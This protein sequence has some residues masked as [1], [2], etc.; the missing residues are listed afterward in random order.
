LLKHLL[1]ATAAASILAMV[2]CSGGGAPNVPGSHATLKTPT[3]VS[4][5]TFKVAPMV[6]TAIQPASAMTSRRPATTIVPQ[7]WSSIP[8]TATAVT[9]AADGSIWVLSDQPA[10]AN[11]FI[12]H[13]SAGTWT[14]V[15]G[16]ASQIA[17]A[18]NG[19]LYAVNATGGVY[20]YSSGSWTG[21]GGGASAVTA[22]SDNTVYVISNAGSGDQAIYHYASN[23]WTQVN[24]EGVSIVGS[25]DTTSH[26]IPNGT[27]VPGGLYIVNSIGSIYYENPDNTFVQ[28]PAN[29]AEVASSP[30][31]LFAL[32]YPATGSGTAIYYYDLDTPGWGA[33]SGSG[34]SIASNDGSLFVIS[35]SG[36]IYST[37]IAAVPTPAGGATPFPTPAATPNLTL[38]CDTSAQRCG[39][40]RWRSKTLDDVNENQINWTPNTDTVAQLNALPVPTGYNEYGPGGNDVGRFPPYEM[41]LFT[42]RA[43][44]ITR[45][46]ETG[47]SGDDDYH[48]EISDPNNPAAT[49]VTEAPH[50]ECTYAC[51]S[52]FGGFFDNI[53]NELDT[54]FGAATSSFQAFPAGVV[55]NFTGVGFF[56]GLHG[57]TG[58]LANPGSPASNFELHPLLYMEFVSGKPNVAGC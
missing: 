32:G 41:E 55:V 37:P 39:V 29:A 3:G 44:L 1:T 21:L 6:T 8:G 45:K 10:G 36:G 34:V 58:A 25:Q 35:G 40:E 43:L 19:T 20:A 12:W 22:A 15:G 33:Q 46:H 14:N 48:I 9:A 26:T 27:L 17:V 50:G 28:V 30:G 53:R 31:G 2:A 47:S 18:P 51:A 16:M 4:P 52:G 24:G 56:D 7:S 42:V 13:Y 38:S 54:C 57:Q 11:K 23:T 5:A 49:M